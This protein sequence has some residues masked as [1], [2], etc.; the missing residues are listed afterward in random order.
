M[1]SKV[2]MYHKAYRKQ[3]EIHNKMVR[4]MGRNECGGVPTQTPMNIRLLR[5]TNHRIRM[6]A[7]AYDRAVLEAHHDQQV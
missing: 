3:I 5:L 1:N 2:E 6:A 7:R 4:D